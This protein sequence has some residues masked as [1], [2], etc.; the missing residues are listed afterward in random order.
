MAT[1]NCVQVSALESLLSEKVSLKSQ[2][3][4]KK[5]PACSLRIQIEQY[6]WELCPRTGKDT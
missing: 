3:R 5:E 2:G 4:K 6:G 1:W